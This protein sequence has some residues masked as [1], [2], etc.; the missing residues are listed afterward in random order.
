MKRLGMMVA[1]EQCFVFC[2]TEQGGEGESLVG[3]G[4]SADGRGRRRGL[5]AGERDVG[6][7][8]V[9]VHGQQQFSC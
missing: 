5:D 6:W 7:F 3:G 1:S 4:R 9:L 8:L 2:A